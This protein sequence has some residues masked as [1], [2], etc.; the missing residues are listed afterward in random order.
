[1]AYY[2]PSDWLY[3]L[4][5]DFPFVLSPEVLDND[6]AMSYQKVSIWKANHICVEY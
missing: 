3:Q 6:N 1:M 2:D 5:E 4:A